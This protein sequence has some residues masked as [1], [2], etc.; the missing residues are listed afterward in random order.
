VEPLP[1][2]A[3]PRTVCAR[4]GEAL[5]PTN[6]SA[7]FVYGVGAV[8]YQNCAAC[9]AKWRY[10]WRDHPASRVK[11]GGGGRG[12]L[13]ALL[14]ALVVAMVVVVGVGAMG[15]SQRWNSAS[16]PSTSVPGTTSPQT[17]SKLARTAYSNIADPM[18]A[19]RKEF[20]GWVHATAA[21]TP[22]YQVDAKVTAY[23]TAARGEP[24]ELA[25]LNRGSWPAAASSDLDALISADRTFV[26]DAD[27]LHSAPFL[28]SPSFLEKLDQEALAVRAA[29]DE[30]RH[31]L[32][33]NPVT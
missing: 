3:A 11:S 31:A 30:V 26:A 33:L 23:V 21:S 29:D 5:P 7:T 13:F 22:Q 32:G 19:K 8:G 15:R 28:Y 20:M 27:L 14:G 1:T 25:A 12:R 4:C 17:V 6:G 2:E 9:G 24:D 10:L 18:Y 16:P